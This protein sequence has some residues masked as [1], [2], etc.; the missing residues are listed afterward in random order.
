[1]SNSVFSFFIDYPYNSQPPFVIGAYL[2]FPEQ[3][4]NTGFLATSFMH[5]GYVGMILFSVIVGA[6]LRTIDSLALTS[7]LPIWFVLSLVV[8]PFFALQNSA[9]LGTALLT[10]GL[11]LS[12]VILW[13]FSSDRSRHARKTS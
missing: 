10:H 11:V 13:L 8:V 2:G 3:A 5:F 4:A 7:N 1:M 9:D 6:I 12:L